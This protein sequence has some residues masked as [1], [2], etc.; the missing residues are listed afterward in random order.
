[1]GF[2]PYR[3][4]DIEEIKKKIKAFSPKMIGTNLL[5]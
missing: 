3:G 1:M 5:I 4:H 2:N